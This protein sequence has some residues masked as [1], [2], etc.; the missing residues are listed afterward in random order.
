ME[1][2][3]HVNYDHVK[4]EIE[5]LSKQNKETMQASLSEINQSIAN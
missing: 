2:D 3:P 1:Y 4:A 5:E